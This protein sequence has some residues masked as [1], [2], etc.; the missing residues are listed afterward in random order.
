MA[1]KVDMESQVIKEGANNGYKLLY[2]F[3]RDQ[4]SEQMITDAAKILFNCTINYAV[5]TF[6][7]LCFIAYHEKHLQFDIE[8]FPPA[9]DSIR[10]YIMRAYFQCYIW[11]CVPFL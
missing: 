4:L 8:C 6:S 9:S 11:L 10:Q 2:Y 5:D 3:G 7:E 1:S